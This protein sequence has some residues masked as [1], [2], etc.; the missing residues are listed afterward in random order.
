M[1]KAI[2]NMTKRELEALI[3][4]LEVE[5][6]DLNRLRKQKAATIT[7][8]HEAIANLNRVVPEPKVS[9]HALI[10][11]IERAKGFNVE[12]IRIAMLTPAIVDA[13]RAGAN[14][15]YVD[16]LKFQVRD[17]VITTVIE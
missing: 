16:G 1:A 11:F 4:T 7:E 5:M 2:C 8:A 17:N 15:V 6:T 9:D 14:A 3:K 13:I 10:R 12:G